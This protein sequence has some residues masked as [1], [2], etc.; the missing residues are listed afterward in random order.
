M[1]TFDDVLG[2][3][4]SFE[5]IESIAIA[6]R[7]NYGLRPGDHVNMVDFLDR[8]FCQDFPHFAVI[9]VSPE[10]IDGDKARAVIS[11]MCIKAR[12]DIFLGASGSD[13]AAK[14]VIAHEFGHIVLHGRGVSK[15]LRDRFQV[16]RELG[17]TKNM[18]TEMQADQFVV[19]FL[20][21]RVFVG[22]NPSA[23][24]ISRLLNV[25]EK[26][27]KA[28]LSLYKISPVKLMPYQRMDLE[29]CVVDSF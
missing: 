6:V 13:A 14:E 22:R 4:R 20:I 8:L 2:V 16:R 5:D 23:Y 3:P 15:P 10:E 29:C 21:P 26:S 11:P 18:S 25:T 19:A 9:P 7:K 17:N 28:A 1:K 27:A 12:E 24:A